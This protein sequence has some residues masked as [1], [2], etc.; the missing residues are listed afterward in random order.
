MAGDGLTRTCLAW[1]T[2]AWRR[3]GKSA[4]GRRRRRHLGI[5]PA[6]RRRRA[7]RHIGARCAAGHRR[8]LV[9]RRR[10][11][12]RAG[13]GAGRFRAFDLQDTARVEILAAA[14]H[15][16]GAER[17]R[18]QG[19]RTRRHEAADSGKSGGDW[20][21]H[22]DQGIL[23]STLAAPR[24]ALVATRLALAITRLAPAASLARAVGRVNRQ[25]TPLRRD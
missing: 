6:G 21:C 4:H 10:I 24:P 11:H 14:D 1:I 13:F 25:P 12:D 8:A 15:G 5:G 16:H 23:P 17:A 18:D 22:R 9:R 3:P 20:A 7:R 19:A 2:L